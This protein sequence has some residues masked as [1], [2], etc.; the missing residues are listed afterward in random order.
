MS[1]EKGYKPKNYADRAE[2]DYVNGALEGI[3]VSVVECGFGNTVALTADGDV[4][5]W[6]FGREGALGNSD[7]EDSWVPKK[8]ESLSNI[9]QVK[10]GGNFVI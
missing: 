3:K 8:I 9:T 7:F 4:F 5:T 2:I 6:G 1:E 10:C